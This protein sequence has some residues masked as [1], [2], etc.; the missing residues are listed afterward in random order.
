MLP[1]FD[2]YSADF[3]DQPKALKTA[4][5]FGFVSHYYWE[6]KA[7]IAVLMGSSR[8]NVEVPPFPAENE[9]SPTARTSDVNSNLHLFTFIF[10]A[11]SN[12]VISTIWHS[13]CKNKVMLGNSYCNNVLQRCFRRETSIEIISFAI[14]SSC[15][16]TEIILNRNS[17]GWNVC[18]AENQIEERGAL[19]WDQKGQGETSL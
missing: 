12:L 18:G 1:V 15:Q 8:K 6:S 17:R 5:A 10:S 3:Q 9:F 4:G 16:C 7:T 19:N 2:L 13:L 11:Y 14:Y